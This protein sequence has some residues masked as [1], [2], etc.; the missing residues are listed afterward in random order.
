MTPVMDN[1]PLESLYVTFFRTMR[2]WK[3]VLMTIV[4]DNVALGESL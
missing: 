3:R 2:Q 1:A 4:M